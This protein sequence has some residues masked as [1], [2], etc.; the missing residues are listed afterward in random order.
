MSA[1]L[2]PPDHPALPRLTA[3]VLALAAG[4]ALALLLP[5][6]LATP[7]GAHDQV[8]SST[9]A[10]GEHL[11]AAPGEVAMTFTSD[12]L[13]LG[14]IMLVVDANGEDWASGPPELEGAQAVQALTDGLPDGAYQLRWRVVSADGH[15]I[16]GTV[17][18]T[19]GSV[20][21]TDAAAAEPRA[22]PA[23]VAAESDTAVTGGSDFPLLLTG[24]IGA[25]VGIGVYL[26]ALL[27]RRGRP[28]VARAHN[29]TLHH[30]TNGI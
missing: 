4:A 30:P 26:L 13:E 6:A 15:P 27:R 24:L 23:A 20:P 10:E 1:P 21:E 11:A 2:S 16:S 5:I 25:S 7:A 29:N 8:I 14:A 17:D 3:R 9:P 19:I 12:V 22:T 28:H 18:F